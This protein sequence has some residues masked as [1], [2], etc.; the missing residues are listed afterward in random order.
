MHPK[1]TAVTS[2]T[3]CTLNTLLSLRLQ[4]S[5]CTSQVITTNCS[6]TIIQE[7]RMCVHVHVSTHACAHEYW[8]G[9]TNA[10]VP[11]H[12]SKKWDMVQFSPQL[13]TSILPTFTQ[14]APS[15]T[16]QPHTC[17]TSALIVMVEQPALLFHNWVFLASHFSSQICYPDFHNSPLST[18]AIARK[19]PQFI[20]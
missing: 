3:N 19:T 18:W 13:C 12:G 10:S 5:Q 15:W 6:K 17:L 11:C 8:C 20:L 16:L 2:T 1:H 9:C 14:L 4:I 7:K